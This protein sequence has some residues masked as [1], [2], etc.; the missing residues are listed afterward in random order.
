MGD[1]REEE[2]E[3]RVELRRL[4]EGSRSDR[5]VPVIVDDTG[6]ATPVFVMGDNP[7]ELPTLQAYRGK[8][9]R[10][11]GTWRNQTLR[12]EPTAIED[13]TKDAGDER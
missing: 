9:V 2:I 3:G 8:R 11:R 6:A 1:A 5:V 12:V 10:V 4:D 7:F 13:V